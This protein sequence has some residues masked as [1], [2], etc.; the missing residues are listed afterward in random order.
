LRSSA[1]CPGEEICTV[2]DIA[3]RRRINRGKERCGCPGA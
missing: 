3:A 2:F 1:N